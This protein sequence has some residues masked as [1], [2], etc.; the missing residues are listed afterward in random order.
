MD[1]GKQALSSGKYGLRSI[2]TRYCDPM[3]HKYGSFS[4]RFHRLSSSLSSFCKMQIVQ[5]IVQC[6]I[7]R[8]HI[9]THKPQLSSQLL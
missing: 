2:A 4:F 7:I 9:F 5:H 3:E 8:W 1:N 6:S